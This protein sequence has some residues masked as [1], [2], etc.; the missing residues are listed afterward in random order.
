MIGNFSIHEEKLHTVHDALS[1][2]TVQPFDKHL[3]ETESSNNDDYLA[4]R[5]SNEHYAAQAESLFLDTGID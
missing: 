5:V 3:S 2:E 4:V 1:V